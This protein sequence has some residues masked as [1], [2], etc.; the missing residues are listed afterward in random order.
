MARQRNTAPLRRNCMNC[1]HSKCVMS[2]NGRRILVCKNKDSKEY[3]NGVDRFLHC[4]QHK[5]LI[6]V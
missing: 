4:V 5:P 1:I 2:V 6:Y 3:N